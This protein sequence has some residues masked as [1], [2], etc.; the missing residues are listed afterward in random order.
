MKRVQ[1][2]LEWQAFGVCTRLAEK[3]RLS[4][5]SVRVFFIYSSF[6]TLGSPVLVYLGLAFLMNMRQHWRK[7]HNPVVWEW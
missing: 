1:L 5:S 7:R 4:T 3:M 6:L 2:F